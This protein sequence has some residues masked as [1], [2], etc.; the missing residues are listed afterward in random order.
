[1]IEVK[2]YTVLINE[3]TVE[4]DLKTTCIKRPSVLRDDLQILP[5]VITISLTCIKRPVFKVR[6]ETNFCIK[7]HFSLGLAFYVNNMF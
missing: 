5:R 4:P 7:D 2:E 3:Y 6:P 1:M